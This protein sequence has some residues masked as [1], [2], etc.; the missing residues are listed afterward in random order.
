MHPLQPGSAAPVPA[1][2]P[3]GAHLVVFYKVT[4]PVCQMAAPIVDAIAGA[5]PGRVVAFGQ[6]PEEDLAAFR[7]EFG[8][9][10][11]TAPDI[12][13]YPVSNEWG[14]RVV[15]TL[16]L[17]DD[18][19]N[20]ADIVESWDRDGFNRLAQG[21]AEATGSDFVPVSHAGDGLPAF[22]PG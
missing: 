22:R 19:G 17:V 18:S 2:A 1:S 8:I 12:A 9:D 16:F 6:D 20:V 21:L 13:P 15:P 3:E 4:C 11:P 7:S 14:V 5:N 10:V